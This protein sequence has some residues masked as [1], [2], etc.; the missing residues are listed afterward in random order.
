MM[1]GNKKSTKKMKM[2]E[3]RQTRQKKAF[4]IFMKSG[5]FNEEITLHSGLFPLN[6][7]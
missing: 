6:L 3:K 5:Y 4:P 2:E 7:F 1:K